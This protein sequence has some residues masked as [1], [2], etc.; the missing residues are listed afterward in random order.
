MKGQAIILSLL[1]LLVFAVADNLEVLFSVKA[2]LPENYYLSRGL[3]ILVQLALPLAFL[4]VWHGPKQLLEV[5]GLDKGL[6]QGLSLAFLFSVPML[7]G[8]GGLAGFKPEASYHSIYWGI[9]L[10]PLFEE[11]FYRG[12]LF[13]QLHRYGKWHFIPAAIVNAVIFAS[14]HWYQV[15]DLWS[16][17]GVLGIT[18]MGGVFFAWLYIEWN[19]NL[20]LPIF[21]HLFM[22]AWWILFGVASNAAGGWYANIFRVMTIAAAVLITIWWKQQRSTIHKKESVPVAI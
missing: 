5:L 22:N 7:L 14:I 18:L 6:G 21:L 1:V 17:V 16:A 9:L 11:L 20:W 13:G 2:L 4:A 12:F 19:N 3:W 15:S 8:Y 10:A